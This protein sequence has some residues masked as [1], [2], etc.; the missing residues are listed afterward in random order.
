MQTSSAS[1]TT[2][3][4]GSF[5]MEHVPAG[6]VNVMVFARMGGPMGVGSMRTVDVRDGETTTVEIVERE[7]LLSGRVTRSGAPGSGLRLD[8]Q[9]SG[10]VFFG[11]LQQG[12]PAAAPTGPQR[13]TALTREDGSFEMLVDEP[14]TIYLNVAST[15][16]KVRLPSRM[17]EV[18]D[19][20]AHTVDIAYN[21]V[22]VSGVVIDK[23]TEA[24]VP[25]SSVGA[26]PRPDVG[27]G[28]TGGL[29]GQ[30]GRFQLELEPGDYHLSASQREGGYGS[31]ELD[32]T[33]GTGGL[34]DLR[35]ALPK[36]LAIAGKVTDATGRPAGGVS[37]RAVA[38][39]SGGGGGWSQSLPDGSFEIG[40]LKE[41]TYALAGDGGDGSFVVRPGVAG[42]ARNVSL[43]LQPGVRVSV[44]V[45]GPD[46]APMKDAYP[47]VSRI[48]GVRVGYFGRPAGPTDAQGRTDLMAP[49]GDLQIWVR[50]DPMGGGA[51]VSVGPGESASVS[52]TVKEGNLS[53]P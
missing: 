42:G 36:G 47:T 53:P 46:G 8:A 39:E 22:A 1:A 31:A 30:D 43:A 37:L 15:D 52:V 5:V 27:R 44:T 18:P 24:P 28:G 45:K 29:T 13:M 51:N 12:A 21:G 48:N 40:G 41:G 38:P 25:Y 34:A 11:G 10:G 49:S 6:R 3:P 16:G 7:I 32:V 33:V 17:V 9:S 35:L 20:D 23:E 50:K 19:A 2:Q 14:G 4:D 26:G